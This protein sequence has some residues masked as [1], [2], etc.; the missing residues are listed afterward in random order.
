MKAAW[1]CEGKMMNRKLI[2]RIGWG[3]VCA[4]GILIVADSFVVIRTFTAAE[5]EGAKKPT[6]T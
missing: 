4:L 2:V 5:V 3:V 1:V 6:E